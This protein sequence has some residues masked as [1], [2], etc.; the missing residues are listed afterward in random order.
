[1]AADVDSSLEISARLGA[2]RRAELDA[3]ERMTPEERLMRYRK[4]QLTI[5]QGWAWWDRHPGEVPTIDGHPEWFARTLCDVAD[6]R[7]A[8]SR[9]IGLEL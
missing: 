1:M 9:D 3:L 5:R 6:S 8:R 4:G 7:S 2:Y